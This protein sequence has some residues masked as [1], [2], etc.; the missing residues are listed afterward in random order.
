MSVFFYLAFLFTALYWVAK[1]LLPELNKF[2][3]LKNPPEAKPIGFSQSDGPDNRITKLEDL[4]AE[5]NRNIQLLQMELKIFQAELRDFD[6]VKGLL[7][8]EAIRLRVQN[9]IFRSELGI[10]AIVPSAEL[11]ENSIK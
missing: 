7:E 8:E 6:K 9:R 5:K 2:S 4:L 10:P 3:L 1:I 11:K